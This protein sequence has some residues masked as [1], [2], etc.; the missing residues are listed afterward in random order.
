MTN[1]FGYYN[2]SGQAGASYIVSVQAKQYQ[3]ENP[4]RLINV[5]DELA[6]VDF[7]ALAPK[8]SSIEALRAYR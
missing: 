5:V 3:F 2:S 6:D 7:T 8:R 1:P 4:I